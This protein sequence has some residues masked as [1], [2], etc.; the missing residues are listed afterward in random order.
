MICPNQADVTGRFQR[1]K[2]IKKT[3]NG[4]RVNGIISAELILTNEDLV[5]VLIDVVLFVKVGKQ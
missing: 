4:V 5:L 3:I 1:Y 2:T